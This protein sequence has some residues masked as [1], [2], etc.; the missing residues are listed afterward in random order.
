MKSE[1]IYSRSRLLLGDETM[2][3]MDEIKV[4]VFGL[5][6]VGSWCAEGLLRT[7]ITHITVVDSDTV[8][9]SNLN[10]QLIATAETIGQPKAEVMRQRLLSINPNAQVVAMAKEYSEATAADFNLNSYDYVIDAIDSVKDK[11]LLILNATSASCTLFSAMGAALKSD[12]GQIRTAEFWKVEGCPL[13]ATLRRR[14][15][16]NKTFP[17][18]KFKCVYSKELLAN[19]YT[20]PSED[21]RK[22]AVNGSLMQVTAV[23]GLTLCSLVVNDLLR[24]QIE[25]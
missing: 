10:R 23:S 17:K 4:I 16:K 3:R 18:K 24:K 1:E 20:L 8:A 9:V 22:K 12:P 11:A 2:R 13:G 21:P 5:G 19:R 7:G 15:K 25:S 14:F 6:G